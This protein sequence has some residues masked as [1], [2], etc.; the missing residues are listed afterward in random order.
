MDDFFL[1]EFTFED[2]DF[3]FSMDEEILSSDRETAHKPQ[4]SYDHCDNDQTQ[5]FLCE[6]SSVKQMKNS[7]RN[8][9]SSSTTK[10]CFP[11][12]FPSELFSFEFSN[13]S[14]QTTENTNIDIRSPRLGQGTK[15]KGC[16]PGARS[17][18]LA[19]EH[20]L[21][22]RKRR[23]KL[24]ERFIALSALIPGLKKAD[25]ATVLGNAITH[26]KEL[27][28]RIR[29]LEQEKEASRE[30]ETMI[31]VKK[32]RILVEDET[33][34]SSFSS[35]GENLDQELPEI[36]ANM[37]RDDVLIRLHCEKNKG[38]IVR[39]LNEIERLHLRVMNSTVLPF[40]DFTLDITVL[41]KKEKDFC[42]TVKDLVKSL[43]LAML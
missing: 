10:P 13:L 25:K 12:N 21:A 5:G 40:G 14:P 35:L 33:R 11:Y 27:Q 38:C 1:P 9:C 17:P 16:T 2:I 42:M 22:E 20:V 8:S 28:E 31:V 26:L 41:A 6:R 34:G 43:K 4:I 39:I 3:D 23:E 7:S 30:T 29:D 19:K 18:V 15:R 32:S 24:S 37:S 36:E